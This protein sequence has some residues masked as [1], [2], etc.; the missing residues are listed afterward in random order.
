MSFVYP[1]INQIVKM[2]MFY[3]DELKCNCFHGKNG[4]VQVNLQQNQQEVVSKFL[5]YKSYGFFNLATEK[6]RSL[7]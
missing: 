6:L 2:L 5:L 3:A 1:S 7:W 4:F